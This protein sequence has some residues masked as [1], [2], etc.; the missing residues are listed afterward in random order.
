MTKDFNWSD[1]FVVTAF[2]A[3]FVSTA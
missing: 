3:A 1:Q 2:S